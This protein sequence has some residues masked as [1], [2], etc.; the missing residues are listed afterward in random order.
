MNSSDL[1]LLIKVIAAT[2]GSVELIYKL[3]KLLKKKKNL[4]EKKG[5]D[6]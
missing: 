1:D 3:L 5:L 6:N 4:E 2:S